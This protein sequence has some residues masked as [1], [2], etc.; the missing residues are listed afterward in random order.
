MNID[1][2]RWIEQVVSLTV[3]NG[4]SWPLEYWNIGIKNINKGRELNNIY[5]SA[6]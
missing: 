3:E 4:V 2:N 5:F 6:E 1:S